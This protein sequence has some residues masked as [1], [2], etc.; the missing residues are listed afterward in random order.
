MRPVRAAITISAPREDVFDFVGDL[1]YRVSWCDHYLKDFRLTRPRS[2]GAGAAARFRISPRMAA[3]WAETA[4]VEADRPRR[5]VEQGRMGRLG[6]VPLWTVW[7]FVPVGGG[8][9]RVELEIWT[10]P[11]T[12]TDEFKE[13]FGARSWFK[14]NVKVA[15]ARLR[16]V[17]EEERDAP[18]AR[19]T[20]AGWE[21]ERAPRFGA[22]PVRRA[23]QG[24]RG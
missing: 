7:D 16:M 19:A 11:S 13:M 2:S 10:E 6:R 9:T 15:L 12:R 20:I 23:S 18:L 17:F 4:I 14:G 21:Q 3:S 24:A 5:I 1:A 8:G 22:H